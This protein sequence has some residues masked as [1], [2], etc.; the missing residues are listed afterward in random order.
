[1]NIVLAEEIAGAGREYRFDKPAIVF[2]RNAAEC[3]IAFESDRFP[4]VSR[5]H[6]EIRFAN[7]VWLLVDNNSSYGTYLNG[8]RI[9]TSQIKAGDRIQFGTDGPRFIII[10]LEASQ[11]QSPPEQKSSF[12]AEDAP[13][14]LSGLP[15]EPPKKAISATASPA[16][17]PVQKQGQTHEAAGKALPFTGH[18]TPRL[19]FLSEQARLDFVL[20]KDS[21]SLGRDSHCDIVFNASAAMV[22]RRHAEIRRQVDKYLIIDNNSFNGTLVNGQRITSPLELLDGDKI[23]LGMGGPILLFESERHKASEDGPRSLF[24]QQMRSASQMADSGPKTIVFTHST[25][26]IYP[27]QEE[28]QAQLVMKVPFPGKGVLNVGREP[29]NEIQLDGLQISKYHA[30]FILQQGRAAVEDLGSTN[31]TFVAGA[32][33]TKTIIEPEQPVHIGPFLLRLEPDGSIAVYDTRSKTRIDAVG[34]TCRARNRSGSGYV[35]L[36]KEVSIAIEP[37]EFIGILGPSGAGK[38]TL[39][40]AL[41]GMRPANSGSVFINDLDLYKN[42]DSLKQSI[43]YVPQEDIIHR[44]LSVYKTLYYI[45]KLRLAR[46]ASSSEVNQIVNEVLDV[47]G[48]SD[49]RNVA[50]GELSGGQRKRVST[51]VELLTKPSIIFLDEP[52]SGLDPATEE[53]MMRLFRQIAES[54]R[55]VVM[56]THAMENVKLFDKI[57]VLMRGRLVFYGPPPEALKFLEAAGYKEL[58]KKLELSDQQ[59]SSQAGQKT[60]PETLEQAAESWQKKF[61]QTPAFE[62]YIRKPLADL[63]ATG[64]QFKR[65][66]RRLGLVGTFSQWF[67]LTRRYAAVLLKDRLNLLI[68]AAQAPIIAFL[69]YISVEKNMP[70]DFLYFVI[71]LVSF[72][73]GTSVAAREIVRERPVYRRERMV[74]LG[75]L[76]YLGSKIF[77]LGFIV[78]LQC[79]ILFLPLKLLDLIGVMPMPGDYG[80]IPQFWVMLLTAAVGIMAGLLI[81][82]LVRTSERA[83]S[84]VPLVLIP[85]IL[86]SGLVSAPTGVSKAASLAMPA[87]WSF[88]AMKRYSGLDTLESDGADPK[89]KTQGLGLYKWV[90]KQN[91]ETTEKFKADLEEF[92]KA[93]RAYHADPLNNPLPKEPEIGQIQNVPEDLSGYITFMHPWMNEILDQFVLSAMFFILLILTAITLRLQDRI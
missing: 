2:G 18:K 54:G 68:L 33:I 59:P 47:V 14:I 30:R 24:K 51:A 92:K 53:R 93:A 11:P 81:S 73:F 75:I 15:P 89:G 90:K 40:Q 83:T 50:V 17:P 1:M 45:A 27:Q 9:T 56:T 57:A 38:S 84:L 36:L 13:K 49:R 8:N 60:L 67:T 3:D 91:E 44:E 23:Q 77:V 5:R 69:T 20:N 16:A 7:G 72:W 22:S 86:L 63:K 66:K 21:V 19:K 71:S 62:K 31:G 12:I 39:I 10:W 78:S 29:N 88:D 76:P 32:R 61:E 87:A 37:N 42:L 58:F 52:T 43:G 35:T 74:N 34:L 28:A 70:R 46:D 6:A 4:M 79:F 48:L 26:E 55:T 25:G 82:T 80:G 41:N 64:S 65:K 85:Q